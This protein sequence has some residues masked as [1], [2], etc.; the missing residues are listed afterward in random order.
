MK[1][2]IEQRVLPSS[3]I[4]RRVDERAA[5]V[6]QATGRKPGKKQQ[7]EIKEEVVLD[8][9]PQ[10]FTKQAAIKVWLNPKDRLLMI[11]ATSPAKADE[12]VTHSG[13]GTR[14]HRADAVAHLAI[15]RRRDVGVAD[16][17]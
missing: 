12:V 2:V 7:K 13:Q 17:R 6:E 8:L 15:A 10:A 1:L 4:K 5:Q 9:L 16:H 14:R 11:D 3:V